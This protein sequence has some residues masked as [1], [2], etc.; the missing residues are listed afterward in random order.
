[1]HVKDQII[2]FLHTILLYIYVSVYV[3]VHVAAHL[4]VHVNFPIANYFGGYLLKTWFVRVLT[5]T[6]RIVAGY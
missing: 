5:V 2:F 4:H 6:Y 3:R 1:M